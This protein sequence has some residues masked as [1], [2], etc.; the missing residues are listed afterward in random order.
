MDMP[1]DRNSLVRTALQGFTGRTGVTCHDAVL[2]WLENAGY[3]PLGTSTRLFGQGLVQRPVVYSQI[4]VRADDLRAMSLADV[5]D[6]PK[7]EVIGF[8]GEGQLKH[9]V[10]VAERGILVGANNGGVLNPSGPIPR[11]NINL[12]AIFQT[13]QLLWNGNSTV[14]AGQY[15]LCSAAPDVV[16]QRINQHP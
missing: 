12:H 4:L 3:V 1:G 9:S 15:E 6:L 2:E 10:L 16:A 8:W 11:V 5:N 7:G 14:G 13:S